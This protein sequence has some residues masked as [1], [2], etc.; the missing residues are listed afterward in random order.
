MTVAE[1][2]GRDLRYAVRGLARNPVFALSALATMAIG[3]GATTA[4]FS[5]VDRILY[6]PLPYADPERL[7]S[8]GLLAPLDANEF[9]FASEYFDLR[10]NPGPFSAVTCFQAGTLALDVT[11]ENPVRLQGLR[12]EANFLDVLGAPLWHGRS[13][14]PIEDR[15][16]GPRV[17]VISHGLWR[18]RFGGDP[19]AVGRTLTIDGQA[20]EVVGVLPPTFET[21]TLT[22]ADVLLPVALDESRE[23]QGRA[24]RVFARLK[25]GVTPAQAHQQLGPHMARVMETVPPAF[26]KEVSLRVRGLRDRQVGFARQASLALFGAVLAV[27]LIACANVA[28]LLLARAVA[29]ERELAVRA[30]L[31]ASRGRLARQALTE[32]LLI[33]LGGGA[34]G[35]GLAYILLRTFVSIAPGGLPRL[36]E[37]AI[38]PRVLVFTVGISTLCGLLFGISPALRRPAGTVLGGWRSTGPSRGLLRPALVALQLG[39]SLALL[40]AAGLLLRS[41]WNLERVP[42]GLRP[43][44][45]ITARFVLGSQ[46]YQ[47]GTDQLRF[48]HELEEKLAALPGAQ[49]TAITDSLPPRGGYRGR[50]RH[51]IAVEGVPR[52]A[53]GTGGMVAWR[54][55]SPGYFAALGIPIVQG[56]GFAAEDRAPSHFAVVVSQTLARLL[57][58]G[59]DAVGKRILRDP[60][61]D[62]FTVVGVAADV[63]RGG[64]GAA[65]EPE[66]YLLR[67]P[68]AD[69]VWRNQEP[70][71]GWRA[72]T[73]VV[74]S[75]LP[76]EMAASQLRRAIAAL[77][78]TAP[79]EIE[80]M[81][82]R[83]E[84]VNAGPRFNAFLL[85]F[86]AAIALLLAAVGLFG[87]MSFV[88][89]QR[90]R[91]FGVRMALGATSDAILRV[92]L[93]QALRWVGGGVLLGVAGSLAAARWLR[94]LLFQVDPLDPLALAVALAV[95]GAVA[96]AAAAA[97]ARR[98]AGL[99]PM[100]VLRE[101]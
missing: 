18:T 6:R 83:L 55:I 3:I 16:N 42:T 23:R 63:R 10:Q 46:R 92:A 68:E 5:V 64:P 47:R 30:A 31:G 90:T 14:T 17:A 81:R 44:A 94:S 69:V 99:S 15:P 25:E 49:A 97:P 52:P 61:N 72:A 33:A 28:N 101:E 40:T 53:E 48:F 26:R 43:D 34:A 62:W 29:R 56:R 12:V 41:L 21:P 51:A 98:A 19:K 70:P 65:R 36:E 88:V 11:E 45:V 35:C 60:P 32:S 4:V 100:T 2:V 54:Y 84:G 67:K 78:N 39:V 93:G 80:T 37:A 27:L 1:S 7:V 22:R 75:A 86:A 89:A 58:P 50:P 96:L 85:A 76:P 87:V 20:T 13:F 91:E 77:D 66:Y 79:V 24:L 57:F 8:V 38:D 82:E 71:T 9:M 74:R 59:R 73:A 95:L